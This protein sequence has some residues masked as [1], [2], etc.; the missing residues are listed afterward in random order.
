MRHRRRPVR[1][2]KSARHFRQQAKK[3]RGIN[4]AHRGRG[5]FRI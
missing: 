1:K 4:L 5:G 2:G 3:T